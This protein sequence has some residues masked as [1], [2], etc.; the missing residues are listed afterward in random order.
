MSRVI[1]N[2]LPYFVLML[3]SATTY[4]ASDASALSFS[5]IKTAQSSGTS[6]AM[7]VDGGKLFTWRKLSHTAILVRHPEGD[8]LW[9]TGI[10][11][12]AE[13]QMEEFNFIDSLLFS[14]ENVTPARQQLDANGY[15]ANNLMA[16][17]PS[18]MHWDHASGIEDFLGVPV[19]VQ[20]ES[21]DEAIAGQPPGFLQSQYDNKAIDWQILKMTDHA[22]KGFPKS[23]DIYGDGTAVLV[24]LS[25][26][27]HG[28]LGLFLS[29]AGGQ[30]YFFVGDT[31]WTLKG[32][33]ENKS[34]PSIE[35][36]LLGVDTDIEENAR[37]LEK[38]HRLSKADSG[39]V[40]VAAHDEIQLEKLPRHPE[41]IREIQ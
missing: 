40:I 14:I 26:H 5:A 1:L 3:G 8:F 13:A 10:G 24:D 25:G 23:F 11:I 31:A 38:I 35:N 12:E 18:H 20:Q 16:I 27:T 41:F 22:Y 36:W 37:V 33:S 34:R 9:D 19:W 32:V 15:D 17:I 28:Q 30:R 39:L 21:Y 29:T 2:L 6:E 4:A 7:V